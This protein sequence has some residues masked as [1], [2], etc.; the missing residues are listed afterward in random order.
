[1]SVLSN[2]LVLVTLT[3]GNRAVYDVQPQHMPRDDIPYS[4]DWP[5]MYG[6]QIAV[7]LSGD[8][9]KSGLKEK[10]TDLR[11]IALLER[12]ISF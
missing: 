4:I 1:M 8:W 6:T 10:I 5:Q 9:Y 11:T 2:S 12:A 7:N 3:S